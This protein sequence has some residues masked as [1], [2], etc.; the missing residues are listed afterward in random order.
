MLYWVGERACGFRT[1][2]IRCM[3]TSAVRMIFSAAPSS[4]RRIGLVC[5]I[6]C[7]I[8]PAT[9]SIIF[10]YNE[11]CQERSFSI[12]IDVGKLTE[13]RVQRGVRIQDAVRIR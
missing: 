7:W 8:L 4:S 2:E 11:Y 13:I 3:S 9:L 6:S 5:L 12:W 10:V 1:S